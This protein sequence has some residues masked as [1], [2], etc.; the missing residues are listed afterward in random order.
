MNLDFF[1]WGGDWGSGGA[2]MTVS[3]Q[4]PKRR[5]LM[6]GDE[7]VRQRE[8]RVDLDR[9]HQIPSGSSI[10]SE[11]GANGEKLLRCEVRESAVK[12]SPWAAALKVEVTE[13][14]PKWLPLLPMCSFSIM[15]TILTLNTS[16]NS[17]EECFCRC[18]QHLH[19]PGRHHHT[20][21]SRRG[22]AAPGMGWSGWIEGWHALALL[23]LL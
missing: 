4:G 13:L 1:P 11:K 12:S 22:V 18:E 20:R 6:I 17:L 8:A 9:S 10:R 14:G 7:Q 16:R 15:E 19:T 5:G 2:S 3:V 23:L 21:R